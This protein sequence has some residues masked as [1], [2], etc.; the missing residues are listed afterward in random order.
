MFS[1]SGKTSRGRTDSRHG[2]C[3][4]WLPHRAKMAVG[5]PHDDARRAISRRRA[6]TGWTSEPLKSSGGGPGAS[7]AAR[8]ADY[9]LPPRN[10]TLHTLGMVSVA[11]SSRN[12]TTRTISTIHQSILLARD[13]EVGSLVTEALRQTVH[14]TMPCASW[15]VG[16]RVA[17]HP[18]GRVTTLPGSECATT[19]RT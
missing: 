18:R 6:A 15:T 7:S 2:A 1:L 11:I 10:K 4:Y 14:A 13:C 12:A 8:P 17:F 16:K 19:P 9:A 5:Q 3:S